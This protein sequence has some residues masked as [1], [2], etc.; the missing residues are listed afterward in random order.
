MF[1]LEAKP[2][3]SEDRQ[4]RSRSRA[5]CDATG[6]HTAARKRL[7]DQIGDRPVKLELGEAQVDVWH[8][9]L[10]ALGDD[11]A[12][13]LST[14]DAREIERYRGFSCEDAAR[15]FL[16]GRALTRAALSCYAN[17]PPWLWSFAANE[18]GRP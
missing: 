14:L 15:Q 1:S 6:R 10:D 11:Q 3:S 18:H 5:N 13:L 8:C 9:Y 4:S 7:Q 2:P 17:V 16:A 12:A